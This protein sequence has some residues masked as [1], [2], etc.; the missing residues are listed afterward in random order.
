MTWRQARSFGAGQ[1]PLDRVALGVSVGV[2]VL[3]LVCARLVT[4]RSP[5][6]AVAWTVG[7]K[8]CVAGGGRPMVTRQ[9]PG[10]RV[11]D[12]AVNQV[13]VR[14]YG[15]ALTWHWRSPHKLAILGRDGR[16]ERRSTLEHGSIVSAYPLGAGVVVNERPDIV[17]LVSDQGVTVLPGLAR[18]E[19]EPR[20]GSVRWAAQRTDGGLELCAGPLTAPTPRQLMRT[21]APGDSWAVDWGRRSIVI[22]SGDTF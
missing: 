2:V 18:V 11:G 1:P 22:H 14:W 3:C 9:L 10:P 6:Q 12:S 17:R 21:A 20:P 16:C 13:I 15:E 4:P 5:R 8:V 7:G 19:I